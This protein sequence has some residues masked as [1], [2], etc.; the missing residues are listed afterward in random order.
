MGNFNPNY[1][2]T[3]PWDGLT[4]SN[5]TYPTPFTAITPSLPNVAT[6]FDWHIHTAPYLLQYNLNLQREISNGTVLSVGYVGSHGIHLLTQQDQNAPAATIDA[7][8][9]YHFG[10]VNS[11]GTLVANPRLNPNFSFLQM[12]E[13]GTTSRYNALQVSLNR[14]LTNNVQAQLSYTYSNCIDDGGFPIGSLNGGNSP[15]AY[16]NPYVRSIDRGLCFFNVKH[17]LRFNTV[18]ALPFHGNRFKEGWQITGILSATS[19]YPFSISTGYDRVGY[20]STGTPRPNYISGCQVAVGGVNEWFNPA[21]FSLQ[22]P[23][24]LGNV[25]RDNII[26]PT[27]VDVDPALLKDTNINERFR[28]QFRGEIYNVFNHPNYG[29]PNASIFTASGPNPS[30][31]QITSIVGNQRQIQFGLKLIF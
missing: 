8:G 21:C 26:G 31:G 7:N 14:R 5:P 15:T 28:L 29:L 19:G 10:T 20:A 17:A 23:G 4:Q 13:P 16:E 2:S 11:A 1:S 22:A 25:G 6:G 30:A 9:I 24:T 27:Y 3:R 12:A 18:I